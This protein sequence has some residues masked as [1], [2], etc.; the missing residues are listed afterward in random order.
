[1]AMLSF[2]LNSQCSIGNT[3]MTSITIHNI[4]D[5]LIRR[6]SDLAAEHGR[7]MEEEARE[8]LHLVIKEPDRPTSLYESIRARFAKFGDIDLDIPPREPMREPPSFD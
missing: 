8:I 5:K 7:S 3:Q 4:D 1:M 2:G 6:L